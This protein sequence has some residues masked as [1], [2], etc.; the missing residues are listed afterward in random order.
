MR[1]CDP[2][3]GQGERSRNVPGTF[4][5]STCVTQD[6]VVRHSSGYW[7]LSASYQTDGV[8]VLYI[9]PTHSEI[10]DDLLR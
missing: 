7:M 1:R 3:F 4:P 10:F 5:A 2:T 6:P 8:L 9:T